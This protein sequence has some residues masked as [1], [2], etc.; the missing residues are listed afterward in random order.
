MFRLATESVKALQQVD[1]GPPLLDAISSLH[2][3]NTGLLAALDRLGAKELESESLGAQ[4]T[5]FIND[6]TDLIL[7]LLPQ[8]SR[9]EQFASSKSVTLQATGFSHLWSLLVSSCRGFSLWPVLWPS[10]N[11]LAFTPLLATLDALMSQCSG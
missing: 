10:G 2:L 4:H 7:A 11:K 5:L 8:M 6:I 1:P 9:I 3:Q